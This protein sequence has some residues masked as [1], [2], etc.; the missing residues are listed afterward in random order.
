MKLNKKKILVTG[1]HGMLGGNITRLLKKKNY[2]FIGTHKTK[3]QLKN[4]N[5]ELYLD[6][7]KKKQVNILIKKTNPKIVIHTA[8]LVNLEL[9]EKDHNLSKKHNITILQNLISNLSRDTYFIFISSDQVYGKN[10]TASEL[11]ENLKPLNIYGKHKLLGEKLVKNYFNKYIIIRTNIFG[12]NYYNH[13]KGFAQ[14]IIRHIRNRTIATTFKNYFFHPINAYFLGKIILKLIDMDFIGI[15]NI[16]SK[17]KISK[18]SF[19]KK[20]YKIFEVKN[21]ITNSVNTP[22]NFFKIRNKILNLNIKKIL[23]LRIKIPTIDQSIKLY[24]KHLNENKPL[25]KIL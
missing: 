9:C 19:V 14:W 22:R 15:I 16:G 23:K 21:N 4:V 11:D 10:K 17:N 12:L 24:K 18:H 6:L 7:T 8:G 20:F 13:N 1:C 5:K 2:S 25:H 3:N